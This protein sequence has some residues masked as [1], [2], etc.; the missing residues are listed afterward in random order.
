M[1]VDE[2]GGFSGIVTLEDILEEIVGEIRDEHD[3]EA[4]L[5]Q[6]GPDGSAVVRAE[7]RIGD[8]NRALGSHLPD[9]ADFE[10]LGGLLN[11]C[12]GAIPQTGDRFFVGGLELTVAQR[13]DRRVRLVRL[14]RAKTVPPAPKNA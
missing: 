8:L 10:T 12:A 9:G 7:V 13:D 2:Y 14:A 4:P 6:F 11:S 5:P 3:N 1:V